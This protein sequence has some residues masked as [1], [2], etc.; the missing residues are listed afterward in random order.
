MRR[1]L[2]I[3]DVLSVLRVILSVALLAPPALSPTFLTLYATAGLT[4][5]LD[6]FVARRTKTESELG[7]RL[8][9]VADLTLA[10]ICLAKILPT[11]V[12][13]AWLWVWVAVIAAVKVANVVSGFVMERRMVMPH[14]PAN[15][16][17]GFVAFLVPFAIPTFGIVAPSIPACVAAT[18]AAAQEGHLIRTGQA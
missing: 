1:K 10:V 13:P 5:M 9:S 2:T 17:A 6:G 11:L 12:V 4:D 18:F 15:K 3:A 14:T 8:D 16:V 7:A